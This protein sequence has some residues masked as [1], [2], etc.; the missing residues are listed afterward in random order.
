MYFPEGLEELALLYACIPYSW[1]YPKTGLGLFW[2]KVL[3]RVNIS[4]LDCNIFFRVLTL[5][6]GPSIYKGEAP[7]FLSFFVRSR[8]SEKKSMNKRLWE[9]CNLCYGCM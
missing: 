8:P 7:Y 3:G 9:P 1:K 5:N 4:H 2:Q 6:E